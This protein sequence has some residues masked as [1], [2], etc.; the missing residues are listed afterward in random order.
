MVYS[1]QMHIHVL[2]KV[3]NNITCGQSRELE[4]KRTHQV[5]PSLELAGNNSFILNLRKRMAHTSLNL[6]ALPS[7]DCLILCAG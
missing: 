6:S 1:I 3:T 4:K 2:A 5:I 7:P